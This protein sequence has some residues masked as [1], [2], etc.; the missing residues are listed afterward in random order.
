MNKEEFRTWLNYV[1]SD[2]KLPSLEAQAKWEDL[3][4]GWSFERAME[5]GRELAKESGSYPPKPG[6]AFR[7]YERLYGSRLKDY[8]QGRYDFGW[9]IFVDSRGYQT[10]R[11]VPKAEGDEF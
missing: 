10:A 7:A 3:F 8:V 9:R 1:F 11:K 2:Y 5:V 6:N 4:K